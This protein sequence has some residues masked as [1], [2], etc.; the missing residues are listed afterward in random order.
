MNTLEPLLN[1]IRRCTLCSGLPLGPKPILQAGSKSRILIAGQAP[2][3]RTH[4]RGRP[5]D[6]A[7]GDRLRRWLGVDKDTFYDANH[8]AII[9]MGFCYPGTKI[10]NGRRQGDLPPRRECATAWRAQLLASLPR[11]ELT[12]IIGRYALDWH[13]PANTGLT[14]M[15]DDWQLRWPAAMVLPHPSPRNNLL[16]TKHCEFEQRQ[17]P[18]L[19]RR[20]R[21]ILAIE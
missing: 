20:V 21:E 16:L 11:I 7:S 6:D 17:V 4:E 3:A 15:L 10:N 2:G 1:N 14:N 8:F 13:L 12:L 18:A 19:Q 9:P 5:F